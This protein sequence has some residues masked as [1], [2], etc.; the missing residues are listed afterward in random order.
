M[1]TS[2]IDVRPTGAALGA[3]ITGFP[4][5]DFTDRD[6]AFV[7]RAWIEHQV[8][9]FRDTD[10]TDAEQIRFSGHF[11]PFVIHPRQMQQGAHGGHREIL[12]VSN[13]KNADGTPAGDL[14]DGEVNWHTDTWFKEKPP[15]ASILRALEVPPTGGDTHFLNM[16]AAY[17]A[18]PNALRRQVEGRAIHHQT[19][20]D[21]RGDVR[22]GMQVPESSDVRTWPGVDHPIVRTHGESGRKCLYLG[23]RRCASIVGLPPSES[24]T[25]L[26]A[27]WEHVRQPRFMWTQV[28]RAGDMVMWD[29]RCVMHRRDAFDPASIRLMHRT[30]V[31]GE[32]PI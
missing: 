19:V 11:G 8:L 3:D 31:E 32:G 24:E 20:Y 13:R 27:L 29:N 28:W 10:M 6:I 30:A 1:A 18:L 17:D 23:G 5:A 4:F 21:G 16:Y 2:V 7:R 14:G 9:R 12:V 15:S 22:M 25:I 26:D